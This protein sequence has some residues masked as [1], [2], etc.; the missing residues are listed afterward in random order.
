MRIGVEVKVAS[1]ST[2][3][4][5]PSVRYPAGPETARSMTRLNTGA[6]RPSVY[7]VVKIGLYGIWTLSFWGFVPAYSLVLGIVSY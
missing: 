7:K 3:G 1:N 6:M 4:S 2:G 5:P